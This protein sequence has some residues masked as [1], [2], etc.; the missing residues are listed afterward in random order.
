MLLTAHVGVVDDRFAPHAAAV[1]LVGPDAKL[2]GCVGLQVVDDR[3]AG[4]ACLVDPLPVPLP[5]AD[6]VEP[7]GVEEG[8]L[9]KVKSSQSAKM[10]ITSRRW[11]D[12]THQTAI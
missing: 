11:K 1:V 8:T 3:V 2:V 4:G 9:S 7:D 12:F 10:S 5:V 6:G